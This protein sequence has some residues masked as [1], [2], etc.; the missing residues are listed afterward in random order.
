MKQP[1]LM[2][3]DDEADDLQ[4]VER[5]VRKRYG[6]DYTVVCEPS[7][8]AAL[9]RLEQMQ[10]EG[11]QVI[12]LIADAWMPEM[13]GMAFL[14]SA[15]AL[16]PLAKRTLIGDHDDPDLNAAVLEASA[17]DLIDSF[18]SKPL[19]SPDEQFHRIITEMLEEWNREN[20]PSHE[21]LRVIG[22]RWSAQSHEFRDLLDRYSIP[23]GFYDSD[24]EEG[25]ALL[26]EAGCPNGPFPVVIFFNGQVLAGATPRQAADIMGG[27]AA[28]ESSEC[29]LAVVGAGPA[30][31]SAAVYGA[32]EGLKT[33]VIE[34]EAI[35]GQAGTSS[36]IRNYL[37]FPLGISGAELAQRANQQ[38]FL[39]GTR[40]VLLRQVV[41]L[42]LDGE[43][44]ILKLSDGAEI[45]SRVVV[46]A[47]GVAYRRLGVPSL[48]ALVGAG[49]FY[50]G[51]M[52]EDQAVK[53]EDVF[54]AGG[55]NSA[56]QAAVH[57]AR[58]ARHV[59]LLTRRENLAATMSDYLIKEIEAQPNIAVRVNTSIVGGGGTRR[60]EKLELR[61]SASGATETVPAAAL[62]VQI[63]AE[64][65][66]GWLPPVILRD[67][68][69]FIL[70]GPD[71]MRGGQWPAEWPLERPPMP[72]ETSVPG[73]FAAGDV[74]HRSVKRVASAVGEGG[75]T[76]Q[77]I[78]SYLSGND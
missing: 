39:F 78:H 10:A 73:V 53:G 63:G 50:G 57:L 3:V 16:H 24:S 4:T 26:E 48:E 55:G 25:R 76:I 47:M 13:T 70:T 72:F 37:G 2:V 69:G 14:K 5:E 21:M 44:R 6:A 11:A 64:P 20:R 60:L 1:I 65:H 31:L 46:L 33:I 8:Q 41:E 30:G 36:K 45:T 62:F 7:A 58:Y 59:T 32:S 18:V 38:A 61:D 22:E 29:D 66:T 51:T 19:A 28:P 74:R 54:V 49:V 15:H 12:L 34:R 42:H 71:L 52:T 23:F 77:Q 67:E 56:G 17:R 75:V 9:N 43:K 27:Y 35:G 40:F 68:Q